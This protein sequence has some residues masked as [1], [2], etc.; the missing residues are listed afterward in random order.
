MIY[1]I[2]GEDSYRSKRKLEEIVFGYKEKNKSGL[3]LLYIDPSASSGQ[4][5][6]KDFYSKLK[7]NSMFA[8]KKLVVLKNVFGSVVKESAVEKDTKFSEDFLENIKDLES[9]KDIIIVYDDKMPDKRTKLF[10]A[11]S[12]SGR[13]PEGRQNAKCQEF[14]ILQP[15]VLKK[16]V[17]QEFSAQGGPASGWDKTRIEPDAVD[18][19]INFVGGDLWQ[20]ANEINKLSCYRVGGTVNKEDVEKLVRPNTENEIFVTIEAIASKNKKLALSL[21]HK[22]LEDGDN[23]LYLLS[24]I[25]YQ[26]RNFLIIKELQE[27]GV[28]YGLISKKSG[29]HPFVVQ[30]SIHLCSQFSMEQLKKIYLKIFQVDSSIKI[31]N[32]EAETALDLLLS[33]I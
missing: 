7:I 32:I 18:L 21:M 15:A 20:L 29:L 25:A 4:V 28:P 1:F 10:K 23:A 33:E 8:E 16:W 11:L 3:S 14:S 31:G 2:Y 30:K 24:M 17:V 6:F 9:T 5:S 19:L 12:A 13:S 27:S 22:H 26:F